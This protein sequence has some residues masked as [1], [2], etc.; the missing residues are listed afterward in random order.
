MAGAAPLVPE[1]ESISNRADPTRRS[2]AVREIADLF[3][4]YADKL[5]DEQSAFFDQILGQLV[6]RT[7]I[8]TRAH[9]AQRLGPLPNA[10][11]SVMTR[12]AK[13][14]EIAVSGPVLSASPLIDEQ[15]LVEI[16]RHKGQ[17][18]L[19]AIANRPEIAPT[20]TDVILRRGDREVVRTVASNE[21]AEFSAD[22]YA[23]LVKRASNDGMLAITVGQRSDISESHL[24]E[25]VTDA[26]DLV[27]RRLMASASPQR[28]SEISSVIAEVAGIPD[29]VGQKRDYKPAQRA[30]LELHRSGNLNESSICEMAR[31]RQ[32]EETIAAL[33]A[34][35]GV[36][37]E[38]MD[39]L[40]LGE[41]LDPILIVGRGLGFEWETVRAIIMLRL[42]P[43]KVPSAP[44]M[45]IAMTNFGRLVPSTAQRVLRFWQLRRPGQNGW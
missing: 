10:P 43:D 39:R 27:R 31:A 1:L 44:D 2:K 36:P 30:I 14:D 11:A 34:I 33:S 12:L 18:H 23:N 29:P 42:S 40:V 17:E 9:V 32:Y 5:G 7:E 37:I 4:M 20:I 13:D 16:A 38:A 45:D 41:R 3:E 21:G 35:S 28:R 24:K 22:G 6:P 8:A 26:V 15:L 19:S 25:L